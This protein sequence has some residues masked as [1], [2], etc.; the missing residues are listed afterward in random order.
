MFQL[1]STV[2][3]A[4]EPFQR[5][6]NVVVNRLLFCVILMQSLMTLSE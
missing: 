2:R 3:L 5:L 6:W 4:E 1:V